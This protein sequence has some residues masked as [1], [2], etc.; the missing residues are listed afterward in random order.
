MIHNLPHIILH[1]AERFPDR[2]AFG[3]GKR[4]LTFHDFCERMEQLANQLQALGLQKGD[5]VGV[6]LNRNLE[7]AIAIYGV[8]RAGGIYVPLDSHAPAELS[9]FLLEDCGIQILISH[10][11]CK[12]KIKKLLEEETGLSTI[13][14]LEG[15]ANV[16]CVSWNEIYTNAAV[17]CPTF[18]LLAQDLAYIIYTSGSTGKPKGIVHS[19]YSGLAY[20]RL[21]ADLYHITEEDRVSNHAPVFFDISLFG[22]FSAPL[23]GAYTLII[24]DAYTIFPTSLSQLIEK[25][26]LTIWYSVPLALTQLLHQGL[27]DQRDLTSLRWVLY[28]GEAFPPK[29]LRPLMQ[30]WPQARFCNIYGPAEL[31]QCTF[32]HIPAPPS[33][34]DP[35][36]IGEV[37]ANSES[38]IINEQEEEVAEGAVGELLVR[39]ATMMKGYWQRPDLT[40][41]SF[42]RHADSTGF[43]TIYYR[44][45]DLVRRDEAGV[46][47]FLG[48]KDHQV[49]TRGYRVEL[50]AV[51]ALL[52]AHESV[53]EAVVF[54]VR[55][56]DDTLEIEAAV[57]L[58]PQFVEEK[59]DI[60]LQQYLKGKLP[61]YAVPQRLYLVEEFPRTGS[62]KINRPAIHAGLHQV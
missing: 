15:I 51:E 14:G 2:P 7:T 62:G 55:A 25:E 3:D 36:P 23:M 37:W 31:N 43:D 27:L 49:K 54:T 11:S 59:C 24:P 18:S 12:K 58:K 42:F 6:Y 9:R 53:L 60:I 41:R 56:E 38:L 44:T 30:Q 57:I 32:Y 29:Y 33:G 1:S 4:Q 21:S 10:S 17:F 46:L 26:Q 19:H 61:F 45:G 13:I 20:A 35:V 34:D 40:E 8:M 50:G 28:A 47:H 39:S 52:V 5:R 16:S 22:Y 48:R